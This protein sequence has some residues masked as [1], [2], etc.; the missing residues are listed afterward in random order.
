[1]EEEI[2]PSGVMIGA[3]LLPSGGI[4]CGGSADVMAPVWEEIIARVML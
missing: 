2:K 3:L 4:M 1:M